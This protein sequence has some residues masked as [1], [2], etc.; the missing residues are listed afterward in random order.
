MTTLSA[1]AQ[2]MSGTLTGD[3]RPFEGVS[4][5]TRTIRQGELFVALKGPNF[6]G[7]RYVAIAEEKG[8]AGAVVSARAGDSL[9]QITVADTREALG[10]L[11]AA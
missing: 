4:T 5:D 2:S 10:Q 8:A 1:A 3:D 9:A 11:G 7:G 6:D